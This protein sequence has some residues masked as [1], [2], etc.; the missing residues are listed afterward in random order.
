MSLL[1]PNLLRM[2]SQIDSSADFHQTEAK[3]PDINDVTRLISDL[4]PI[5]YFKWPA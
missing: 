2:S 4:N 3:E 1:A 5:S